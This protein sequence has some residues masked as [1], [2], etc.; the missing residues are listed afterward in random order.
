METS[1]VSTT[2]DVIFHHLEASETMTLGAIPYRLEEPLPGR[3]QLWL[4]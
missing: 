2:L 4:R 3:P 1:G